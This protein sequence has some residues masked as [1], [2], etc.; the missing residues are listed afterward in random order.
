MAD[1]PSEIVYHLPR[2]T[3]VASG[4]ATSRRSLQTGERATSATVDIAHVVEAD[5][6]DFYIL[7][8]DSSMLEDREFSL[9]L[10]P[11]GRLTNASNKSTGAGARI[12]SGL[13]TLA[14]TAVGGSR[15]V[16]ALSDDTA[17]A[18]WDA[19]EPSK[20]E[21][22][23]NYA[24]APPELHARRTKA[25]ETLGKLA[26]KQID[27]A[28]TAADAGSSDPEA[29]RKAY[30]T[31]AGAVRSLR[32]LEAELRDEI[33]AIDRHES[34]WI[35]AIEDRMVEPYEI[36]L[37][38]SELLGR[39]T[40]DAWLKEVPSDEEIKRALSPAAGELFETTG[41]VLSASVPTIPAKGA[42]DRSEL[43]KWKFGA[44]YG[45][46]FRHPYP[47]WIHVWDVTGEGSERQL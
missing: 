35:G 17:K 28:T 1:R 23:K 22:P 44:I 41:L 43:K 8:L 32:A 36:S 21:F 3:I 2:S 9:K 40:V 26:D 39:A 38:V 15:M 42:K 45:V 10:T 31:A 24:D 4:V 7:D 30:R 12:L 18:L 13:V 11:D 37:Q 27:I 14:S 33:D 29:A 46:V 19:A 5:N 47:T 20:T 34:A 6:D 16:R 25:K